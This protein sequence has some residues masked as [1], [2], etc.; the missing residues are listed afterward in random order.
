MSARTVFAG[1]AATTLKGT[2]PADQVQGD[3]FNRLAATT[4]KATSF[5]DLMASSGDLDRSFGKDHLGARGAL[6][7]WAPYSIE[8]LGIA[9]NNIDV[10]EAELWQ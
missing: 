8:W 5:R 10:L 1:A 4:R 2:L 9:E 6:N 7:K 3:R